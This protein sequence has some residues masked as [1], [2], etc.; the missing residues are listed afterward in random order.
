VFPQKAEEYDKLFSEDKEIT[1]FTR[2]KLSNTSS[3]NSIQYEAI[4]RV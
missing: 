2:E 3:Q 1:A 4:L